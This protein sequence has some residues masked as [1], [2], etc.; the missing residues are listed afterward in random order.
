MRLP[1]LP[2]CDPEALQLDKETLQNHSVANARQIAMG[3]MPGVAECA[4]KDNHLIYVDI[5]GYQFWERPEMVSFGDF[6]SLSAFLGV[7]RTSNDNRKTEKPKRKIDKETRIDNFLGVSKIDN[8]NTLLK[9]KVAFRMLKQLGCEV[10]RLESDVCFVEVSLAKQ[11]VLF[12]MLVELGHG[13]CR[14]QD[15]D[16]V[17]QVKE[18][19]RKP[20]EVVAALSAPRKPK[21]KENEKDEGYPNVGKICQT[22][23]LKP[24]D[25]EQLVKRLYVCKDS[26][27]KKDPKENSTAAQSLKDMKTKRRS[28]AEQRAYLDR[29]LKPKENSEIDFEIGS[30]GGGG[31]NGV[32]LGFHQL[33]WPKFSSPCAHKGLAKKFGKG[34]EKSGGGLAKRERVEQVERV[35]RDE[36]FVDSPLVRAGQLLLSDKESESVAESKDFRKREERGLMENV[37]DTMEQLVEDSVN[38]VLDTVVDTVEGRE[39]FGLWTEAAPDEA[40]SCSTSDPASPASPPSCVETVSFGA[41]G[42]GTER[43]SA[44]ACGVGEKREKSSEGSE[45]FEDETTDEWLDRLLG[46]D[47]KPPRRS[48]K[49]QRER[50]EELAK[51]RQVKDL[52]AKDHKG[53][54]KEQ[55]DQKDLLKGDQSRSPRS[56]REACV[57]L[58]Q[59]RKPKTKDAKELKPKERTEDINDTSDF[60]DFTHFGN[61]EAK[62]VPK[63]V[64]KDTE[65]AEEVDDFGDF[66]DLD[67]VDAVIIPSMLAQLTSPRLER[68]DEENVER[69]EKTQTQHTV[70]TLHAETARRGR[71]HRAAQA[72]QAAPYSV[73]VCPVSKAQRRCQKS[74]QAMRAMKAPT[75]ENELTPEEIEEIG[76]LAGEAGFLDETAQSEA[77]LDDIDA[78]YSQLITGVDDLAASRAGP[79]AE[80]EILPHTPLGCQGLHGAEDEANDEELLIAIDQ[81]YH[82]M[83]PSQETNREDEAHKPMHVASSASRQ[84]GSLS[85][86]SC[87]EK[88]AKLEVSQPQ[89]AECEVHSSQKV[90]STGSVGS[91]EEHG[92]RNAKLPVLLEEVLWSALLLARAGHAAELSEL[93]MSESQE[94]Q[95]F[96]SLRT[97][98]VSAC[99]LSPLPFSLQQR[100]DVE[101]PELSACLGDESRT[102]ASL[103]SVLPALQKA[104]DSLL[105][106]AAKSAAK[107]TAV[108]SDPPADPSDQLQDQHQKLQR[109]LSATSATLPGNATPGAHAKRRQDKEMGKLMT[110]KSLFRCHS[111]TKPITAVAFMSLWEEGKLALD[112]PVHKYI[113]AFRNMKVVRAGRLEDAKRPITLRHLVMHTSG[114]GYGP[115]RERKTEK[116][117][118]GPYLPLVKRIDSG[119]I[120]NLKSF[121]NELAKFPLQFHPG[122][123]WEYSMGLDVIGRVL[124]IVSGLTL[125]RLFR[126]LFRKMGM[127]DTAFSVSPRKARRQLTAY[128]V[129]KVRSKNRNADCIVGCQHFN[130]KDFAWIACARFQG[131]GD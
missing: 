101:L 55:K 76:K 69:G 61:I 68:I 81:L 12:K 109:P 32:A 127:K 60:K 130:G 24:E 119:L 105:S 67:A 65:L 23:R 5:R 11:P 7:S 88:L 8:D 107:G 131:L 118:D 74:S 25:E 46:A 21:E 96:P 14:N 39:C 33:A 80:T 9:K 120:K 124:E 49:E 128:Y 10:R 31:A 117:E 87:S 43:V 129:T 70:H 17:V 104:R 57:R 123:R 72:A 48:A 20:E 102:S 115:S 108:P 98:L 27:D 2:P 110:E 15:G 71:R 45:K 66:G 77:M 56:Q 16:M 37:V 41:C 58:S 18:Q 85:A 126:Q 62:D 1:N 63:D 116:L 28:A 36:R 52:N 113:P 125:D 30:G 106:F 29:L 59:P 19:R 100:L 78:L 83:I 84:T 99:R 103:V 26:K 93:L 97:S 40:S 64:P 86:V 22:R 73:P 3:Y 79:E 13:P 42:D 122:D 114:L 82:Q 53:E 6:G 111:M 94:S 38:T 112:D 75:M 47:A 34:L 44:G 51:P 54:Q 121:C 90:A 91:S 95:D 4:V 89:G 50:L 35:E 92:R